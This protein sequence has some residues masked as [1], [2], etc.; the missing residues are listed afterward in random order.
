M[1]EIRELPL[2][3]KY[4]AMVRR[5]ENGQPL[6]LDQQLN[7][8][9]IFSDTPEGHQFW[10]DV[11]TND[12]SLINQTMNLQYPNVEDIDR[13]EHYKEPYELNKAGGKVG[14][15]PLLIQIIAHVR[16]IEQCNNPNSLVGTMSPRSQGNFTFNVTREGHQRWRSCIDD[17]DHTA[18][19]DFYPDLT[20]SDIEKMEMELSG[21]PDQSKSKQTK[22]NNFIISA[23]KSLTWVLKDILV[24]NY[25]CVFTNSDFE[26]AW[27]NMDGKY[28][29]IN[30]DCDPIEIYLVAFPIA[31]T[32]ELPRDWDK[33]F[34]Q[35]EM[36]ESKPDTDYYIYNINELDFA[37]GRG[38]IVTVKDHNSDYREDHHMD[39]ENIL[40]NLGY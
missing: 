8:A 2:V 13:I 28:L 18:I 16:Q 7:G 17:G 32:F 25:N 3:P 26:L 14:D 19:Y 38:A 39:K 4:L 9:F 30:K 37:N 11:S 10:V 35:I 23:S 5:I 36:S 27:H 34:E 15:F 1:P 12:V 31:I 21:D 40:T 33:L 20:A 22:C 29:K 6:D 24:N